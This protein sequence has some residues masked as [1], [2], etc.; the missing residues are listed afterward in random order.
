MTEDGTPKKV[1][2]GN[3]KT[4]GT[5]THDDW[6]RER[7]VSEDEYGRG[8]LPAAVLVLTNLLARIESLPE[9]TP[10]G[11]GSHEH[12]LTLAWLATCLSATGQLATAQQMLDQALAI[13]NKLMHEEPENQD[14]MRQ[15]G[16]LLVELG[17]MQLDQGQYA[18]AYLSFDDALAIS[19]K[20]GDQRSQAVIQAQLGALALKQRDLP[21][22]ERRYNAGL[23]IDHELGDIAREAVSWYQLGIVAAARERWDES[24]RS[25]KESLTLVEKLENAAA[26]TATCNQ[27]AIVTQ[28]AVQ[29]AE[30][31]KWYKRALEFAERLDASDPALANVCNNLAALLLLEV[32]AD[33]SPK[34][35]LDDARSYAERAM[36]IRETLGDT[37]EIWTSLD[38]LAAIAALQGRIEE[39]R[40]YRRR[41][42]EAFAAFAGN[43]YQIAQDFEPLIAATAAAAKGDSQARGQVAATLPQLEANDW[44]I[45]AAVQRIWGGERDWHTLVE[46][47]GGPQ[48]LLV[49]LMLETI[50][51]PPK[52][53]EKTPEEVIASL[54]AAIREALE[55]GDETGFQQAFETLAPEEQRTLVEAMHALQVQQGQAVVEEQGDLLASAVLQQF[56]PLLQ[57]IAIV[58]TG[59]ATYRSAIEKALAVPEAR[60]FSDAV[61]HIW[62]GERNAITL[63]AELDEQDTLLIHRV[64]EIIRTAHGQAHI[65]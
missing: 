59:D 53:Q 44:H 33:R 2:K 26:A 12:C 56:E 54:P 30:A 37:Q 19:K 17:N 22:A 11:R 61:Q 16:A 62:A 64:L 29:P 43:R 57:A 34:A 55:R 4:N 32:R 50:A 52:V 49:Q 45:T 51:P 27:L 41:E 65:N 35:R 48:A 5:L 15:H 10:L 40:A 6:M 46:N 3:G 31:E 63:T 47:L 36:T 21:E 60:Q 38:M 39:S 1:H 58:A 20:L 24:I 13:I 8:N 25:Y 18:P 9:G 28:L 14:F 7:S 42:R 23:K